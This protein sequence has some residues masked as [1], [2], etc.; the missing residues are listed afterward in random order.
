MVE[1]NTLA[2]NTHPARWWLF[3][4]PT[5]RKCGSKRSIPNENGNSEARSGDSLLEQ[6][7]KGR[8]RNS[9]QARPQLVEARGVGDTGRESSRGLAG[10]RAIGLQ[11]DRK[12]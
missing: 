1:R 11:N 9:F 6:N 12:L 3:P 4:N 5:M 2:K 7:R 8:L 10:N